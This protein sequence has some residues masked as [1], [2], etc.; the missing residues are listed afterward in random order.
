VS[1]LEQG[2]VLKRISLVLAAALVAL[3]ATVSAPAMSP[4]KLT[5]VDGP[6]FTITLKKGSK[7]V[8]KLKAGTYVLVVQDKSSKHNFHLKGPGVDK[9]TSVK[10]VYK[11]KWTVKLKKG[12]YKYV[13]D[14][15]KAIM[16]GS[17]KVT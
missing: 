17:F 4:P 15:H 1:Y 13:C 12:T 10:K 3:A 9:K 7:K 14:P 16:K 8:S 11:V 6:D 5:A 2:A